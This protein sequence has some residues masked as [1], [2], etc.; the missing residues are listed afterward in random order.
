LEKSRLPG[1]RGQGNQEYGCKL[2]ASAAKRGFHKGKYL[3]NSADKG[4]G[5]L[6][7]IQRRRNGE[8]KKNDHFKS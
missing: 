1:R 6:A 3:L 4:F 2:A 8:E 5:K 7:E